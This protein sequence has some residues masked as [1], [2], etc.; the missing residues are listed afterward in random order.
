MKLLITLSLICITTLAS[1]QPE[2]ASVSTMQE[3]SFSFAHF[4]ELTVPRKLIEA[5]DYQ[6]M[7]PALQEIY[8]KNKY[9]QQETLEPGLIALA[10]YPEL[11]DVKIRYVYQDTKT[12][13]AARPRLLSLFR[14][15]DKRAYTIFVDKKVKGREGVL[16]NDFPF[17]AQV[18]GL[19]HEYAHIIDYSKRSSLNI[20]WLGLKYLFSKK[21]KA[22]LEHKVDRITIER[23]LGWQTLAWEEHIFHHSEASH[24]YKTFKKKLYLSGEQIREHMRECSLYEA[25]R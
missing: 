13:L 1:S 24:Q 18:G 17:N 20:A 8:Q 7:L 9:F 6:S 25:I 12:T 2:A 3:N 21:S 10:F 23:G 22:R 5:A 15:K 11:K 4:N 16:F 19:G 14:S